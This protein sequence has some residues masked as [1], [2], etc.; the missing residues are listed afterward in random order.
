MKKINWI[1]RIKNKVFWVALIPALL[2]LIQAIATVFGFTI[3]LGDLGDKLLTVVNALFAV[4]AIL[5][6]VVD[7]TTP[8]AGD[9]ERALTYK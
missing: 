2:L 3:D 1:V 9:S 8:G 7:P 5:G 4:L 6:V